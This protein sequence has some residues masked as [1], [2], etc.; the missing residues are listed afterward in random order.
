M[1]GALATTVGQLRDRV[2]DTAS[3]IKREH[4]RHRPLIERER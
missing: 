1:R 3:V 4:Y 2:G